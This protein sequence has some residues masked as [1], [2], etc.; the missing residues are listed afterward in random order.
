MRKLKL[1]LLISL[2]GIMLTGLSYSNAIHPVVTEVP[3][4]APD[5]ISHAQI[6]IDGNADLQFQAS[7][8]GWVGDGSY[9]NP[10]IIE[11]YE[12]Y[13]I[14]GTAI[15]IKNTNLHIIIRG[16][17]ILCDFDT[18]MGI[19][20]EHVNNTRIR[21]TT[22]SS[23]AGGSSPTG[24][25][26]LFSYYNLIMYNSLSGN[27]SDWT[28]GI[29]VMYSQYNL[30]RYNT[31]SNHANGMQ[32]VYSP[33][34]RIEDN[35]ITATTNIAMYIS[36][37]SNRNSIQGNWIHDNGN[38]GIYFQDA[39]TNYVSNNRL[40][41]NDN[42][43][44]VISSNS[45]GIRLRNNTITNTLRAGI[46]INGYASNSVIYSNTIGYTTM[47]YAIRMEED[48]SFN[49]VGWNNFQDNNYHASQI[50][51]NGT[52]N[53]VQ[54]NYYSTHYAP[55]NGTFADSPYI[56]EGFIGG[57]DLYPLAYMY[58]LSGLQFI[59][60]L[61]GSYFTGTVRV[62]WTGLSDNYGHQWTY[63][64]QPGADSG[65]TTWILA[66][67]ITETYYDWD[68]S[69]AENGNRYKML[70]LAMPNFNDVIGMTFTNR[71][72]GLF[73]VDN[74]HFDPSMY[75]QR[76][77]I[78]IYGN[79]DLK[80]QAI[81][82][83]W[84]GDGSIENPIII[85]SYN[86]SGYNGHAI[87]ILNVNLELRI[88]NNFIDGRGIT[89]VGIYLDGVNNTRVVNNII[90][91]LYDVDSNSR[92]KAIQL[93][94]S[95]MNYVWYNTI[96]GSSVSMTGIRLDQSIYNLIAY[97][98]ITECY[99][100]IGLFFSSQNTIKDN[101]VGSSANIALYLGT[102]SDRNS[103]YANYFNDN[104]GIGIAIQQNSI[105]FISNNE[106]MNNGNIGIMLFDDANTQ[107]I[108][109]NTISNNLM[110]IF[111]AYG[112]LNQLDNNII[113]INRFEHNLQYA[114]K[115]ETGSYNTITWNNFINNNNGS[116]Q[117][118]INQYDNAIDHNYY[119]ELNGPDINYDGIVDTPYSIDGSLGY[120][121]YNPLTGIYMVHGGQFTNPQRL[122]VVS[123]TIQVQ[124]M[125]IYDNWG[126]TWSY[127]LY[128]SSNGGFTNQM[129]GWSSD[130]SFTWDSTQHANTRRA[131][132]LLI[133]NNSFG[134]V[135][136]TYFDSIFIVEN[137]QLLPAFFTYPNVEGM[138]LSG[139]EEIKWQGAMDNQGHSLK[140]DLFI[141]DVT[142]TSWDL[143]GAGVF[144]TSYMINTK[145][146]DNG[147]YQLKLITYDDQGY[148]SEFISVNFNI[149]NADV[150]TSD[151]TTT[152]TETTTTEDDTTTTSEQ[153]ST[154]V[155]D[156]PE[157]TP[158]SETTS[159]NASGPPALPIPYPG[160][161]ITVA[162]FSFM[163]FVITRRRK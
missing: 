81:Q 4:I 30:I 27:A 44:V 101:Y 155:S 150:T 33:N 67:G 87:Q 161:Y 17:N 26:L 9:E 19:Y 61:H 68:T 41:N 83:G 96:Y 137:H 75:T 88:T 13:G 1:V 35:E 156:D 89:N 20:L 144:D 5:Y 122:D 2:V 63:R 6:S 31:I 149:D 148:S 145:N 142:S 152:T 109:N 66:A 78:N 32:L 42:Y 119:S 18:S 110:G 74:L 25:K 133:A 123:G 157:T 52:D 8:E 45:Y 11:N 57:M 107:R 28:M 7:N 15:E 162:S 85:S 127:R 64:L 98:S 46:L 100:G 24:I 147:Q 134:A 139:M 140:Y 80:N 37:E 111:L 70:L 159:A 72:P 105:N 136:S 158:T 106:V 10:Y 90:L 77:P 97:N 138:V 91:N 54:Y 103:V 16:M 14:T 71:N 51:N 62:E 116:N 130:T 34:N 43:G 114:I 23:I 36:T 120:Y 58:L 55:N 22:I 76:G 128:Y 47:D 129:L 108:R 102:S 118:Y 153:G 124:W 69:T 73:T 121:D 12:F 160:V 104:L 93:S 21:D 50:Y 94:N 60:P 56:F 38:S 53:F 151:T 112:S 141:R 132:F 154:T 131:K 125:P 79:Q 135:I 49:R 146:F 84:P 65:Y 48:S 92:S 95:V 163:V 39:Q 113:T 59:N 99:D 117:V 40:D 29:Y 86:I 115:I 3:E 143:I 82:N 126:N